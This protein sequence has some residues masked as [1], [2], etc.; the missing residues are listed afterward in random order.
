MQGAIRGMMDALGDK[1]SSYMDPQTYQ[2]ANSGLAGE[3]EG[4]GAWV[5]PTADYLT[6][7]SPIPG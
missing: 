7:I 2:D 5:D 1:H 6:I 3:Y 4:I